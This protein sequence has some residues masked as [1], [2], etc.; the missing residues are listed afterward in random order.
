MN[1]KPTYEE[2]EN[3]IIKYKQ[4]EKNLQKHKKQY[5][6]LLETLLYGVE[7]IDTSGKIVFANSAFHKMME[8]EENE[9][10]GT[11]MFD[12]YPD[13]NTKKR[14][15]DFIKLLIKQQPQPEP[16]FSKFVKKSGVVLDVQT[17]W[18]YKRNSD[19]KIIGFISIITDITKRIETETKIK[20]QNSFMHNLMESIINPFYVIDAS[21]YSIITANSSSGYNSDSKQEK[22]YKIT[23]HNDIP[24]S[25]I[26]DECPLDSV[27]K[28]G[29]PAVAEHTHYDKNGNKKIFE[30]HGYPIF[31][32]NKNIIQIIEYQFDITNRKKN[33][34]QIRNSLKE[35]EV[36]LREIHHRVKNNM[37][38]IVSLMRIHSSRVEN[39]ELIH[40]FD[41][42]R[43]RVN[44]MSLIHEALYQ[45]DNLSKI[46]FEIY[47]RKL[48]RN[49]SRA[50]DTSGK[51]IIITVDTSGIEL[52]I[53]QGI[54]V[55]MV[56]SELVSNAFNH[57]FPLGTGGTVSIYLSDLGENLVELIVED[58][59]TRIIIRFYCRKVD[60]KGK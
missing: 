5:K 11:S 18:N 37:Q 9:L 58:N 49:L 47:L 3:Q 26:G 32:K 15:K 7:E 23:H 10:I 1:R 35:K 57:A 8:Y 13:D 24:C 41:D 56:I 46:D 30:I 36:L 39:P 29:K 40:V 42:C 4:N 43:D 31:D 22:C 19:G 6:L 14:L 44:A 16:W 55:G 25:N 53:D 45:S 59:G 28:T 51:G 50:Y 54:A 33:E 52:E 17:D 20:D 48:C 27:K 60:N 2:L 21:D 38:T 34:E 12:L